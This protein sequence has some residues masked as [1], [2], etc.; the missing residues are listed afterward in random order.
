VRFL[1]VDSPR[2]D[3]SKTAYFRSAPFQCQKNGAPFIPVYQNQDHL[4]TIGQDYSL[5]PDY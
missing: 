3:F 2:E 1:I 4:L 5:V